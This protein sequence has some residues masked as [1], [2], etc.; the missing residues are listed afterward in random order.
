MLLR[1]ACTDDAARICTVLRH[2]IEQLCHADH[3][4]DAEVLRG[5]LANKTVDTVVKWMETTDRRLIV[6]ARAGTIVGVGM[7]L[8]TGEIA[9][10]YVA[11]EARFQGVSKSMLKALE[12]YLRAEG[13]TLSRLNSTRT[14]HRFYQAMGYRDCGDP[15]SWARL[16]AR[17]M[18]KVLLPD[19]ADAVTTTDRGSP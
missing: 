18:E 8:A 14:A 6:A 5:W 10:N 11:P 2:S 7:A 4:G 13:Q 9:L 17:P 16:G 3:Q 19:N 15:T 1:D 12:A